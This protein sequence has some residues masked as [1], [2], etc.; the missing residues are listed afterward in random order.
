MGDEAPSTYELSQDAPGTIGQ[1]TASE[2]RRAI[3]GFPQW[4]SFPAGDVAIVVL[5]LFA[6]TLAWCSANAKWTAS[7]WSLP[8]A[9]LDP[10]KNDVLWELAHLKAGSDGQACRLSG[11][12]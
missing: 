2:P 6:T 1:P 7:E 3:A 12:T 10:N 9:Y 11:S 8:T 5:L 4:L